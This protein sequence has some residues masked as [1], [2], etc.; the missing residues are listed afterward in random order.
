MEFAALRAGGAQRAIELAVPELLDRLPEGVPEVIY[1]ALDFFLE[2]DFAPTA[3][4]NLAVKAYINTAS[5][6]AQ[7]G[8]GALSRKRGS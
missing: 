4:I 1:S 5:V 8:A 7:A 3:R 6:H 2:M